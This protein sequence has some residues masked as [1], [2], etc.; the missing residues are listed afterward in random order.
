M[1][2]LEIPP[3]APREPEP[4]AEGAFGEEL[5]APTAEGAF[6]GADDDARPTADSEPLGDAAGPGGDEPA[7]PLESVEPVEPL[8][9]PEPQSAAPKAA[10][11]R[12]SRAKNPEEPKP[13][14]AARGKSS[15]QPGANETLRPAV[16]RLG[17][18]ESEG[19]EPWIPPTRAELTPILDRYFTEYL[20]SL[21][22]HQRLRREA[23]LD[24]F[25]LF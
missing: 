15:A 20:A 13:K 21:R 10:P 18:P 23:N 1:A 17:L 7:E 14:R 5:D 22:E 6:G 8:E 19:E 11:K 2:I 9:Q 24:T 4:A 16:P 12:R 25:R 3:A